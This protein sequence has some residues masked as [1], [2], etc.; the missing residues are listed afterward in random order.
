MAAGR[1]VLYSIAVFAVSLRSS[2][3]K[4]R[5]VALR[6]RYHDKRRVITITAIAVLSV[7]G[8]ADFTIARRR[9]SGHFYRVR[10]THSA[11]EI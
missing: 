5:F 4:A 8:T 1:C 7:V 10:G 11:A 3:A 6:L 9:S 2:R